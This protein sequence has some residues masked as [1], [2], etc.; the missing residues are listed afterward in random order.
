[1]FINHFSE[2]YVMINVAMNATTYGTNNVSRFGSFAMSVMLNNKPPKLT[3]MYSK[4]EKRSA[5]SCFIPSN[6]AA[7]IVAPD[8]LIPGISAQAC[9]NPTMIASFIERSPSF[10]RPRKFLI[11]Q[12]PTAVIR[13]EIPTIFTPFKY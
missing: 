1:M 13:R 7:T 10:L 5:V 6:I 12:R 2:I 8:R 4:N 3:G 11:I 9:A